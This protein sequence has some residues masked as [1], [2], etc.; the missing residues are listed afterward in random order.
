VLQKY[1]SVQYFLLIKSFIKFFTLFHLL[2]FISN[3]GI[4]EIEFY[5]IVLL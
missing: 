1:V 2:L 5:Y 4:D 3:K